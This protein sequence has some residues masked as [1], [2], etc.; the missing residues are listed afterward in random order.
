MNSN[1]LPVI[2]TGDRLQESGVIDYLSN[3]HH[4]NIWDHTEGKKNIE[5]VKEARSGVFAEYGLAESGSVVLFS[6]ADKRKKC[7]IDP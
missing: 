2:L 7:W 6:G 3:F 5:R 4:A 1:G